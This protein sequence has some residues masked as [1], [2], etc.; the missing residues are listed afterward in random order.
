MALDFENKPVVTKGE[1]GKEG[2]TGG[3]GL[4]YA[5]FSTWNEWPTRQAVWHRELYPIFCDNLCGK[6][7]I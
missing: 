5:S 1:R 7:K 6:K 3:F 4:E 2:W